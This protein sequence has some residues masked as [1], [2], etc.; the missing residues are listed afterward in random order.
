[1]LQFP[2]IVWMIVCIYLLIINGVALFQMWWDKRCA[3]KDARRI[4]EKNLFL[5][6]IL[7]GSI[8]AIVG[9]QWFRHKTKHWYFVVG[10]PAILVMQI[11]LVLLLIF[12]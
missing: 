4:P 11:A 12:L 8:G 9:M 7:G 5:S 3:K 1:M 6:A 10:M 2:S